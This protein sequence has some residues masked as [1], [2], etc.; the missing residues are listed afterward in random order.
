MAAKKRGEKRAGAA[1]ESG[2][3]P[4]VA[5]I[6]SSPEPVA[7]ETVEEPALPDGP[8]VVGIGASAGGLDAFKKFFIAMPRES[9]VALVL[10]P[11]LDPTHESL[12]VELLARHTAMP[13]TEAEDGMPVA[14]NRVYIIPPNKYMTISGGVLGLTGPVERRDAQTS[15]DLFLRS[16]AAD[17]QEK[18]VCIILSGTGS[19]GTLGLKAVKAAGGMAMVQDPKTAEYDRMPRSA[20]ATG[21][22]DYVLPVE[23]MPAVLIKYIQFLRMNGGKTE[24]KTAGG[25]DYLNQVLA[26]LRARTKYDFRGYRKRMLAR[27]VERRMGLNHFDQLADYVAFLRDQPDEVKHLTQDL[28]ISVTSFFR[29]PEALKALESEAVTSL[30]RAKGPDSVVRAWVAGCATGE[31]A[32]TI[33]ILLLEHIAAAQPSCRLQIFATDIDEGALEVAR[34]GIYPESIA[35]DV[36]PE[37]LGRFFTRVDESSYQVNKQLR[38]CITFAAQNL[39]GDA[40]FSKMDLVSCRNV[41][42]Y[43]EVDVQKR[44]IPLLHFALNE[45]GYLFLGPSE[46]IGRQ[47]DLFEAVSKKWRIFRRVGPSRVDRV[48]F[49]IT[50]RTE[51]SGSSWRPPDPSDIRAGRIAELAQRAL[52]AEFAPAAV[53]INRKLEILYFNGPINDYLEVPTGEPTRD[54]MNMAREGL[55]TK[56]RSTIHKAIIDN[57]AVTLTDGQVKRAGAYHPVTVTVRPLA[58]PRVAEGLLLVTFR[59]DG[60]S[61]VAPAPPQPSDEEPVVRQLE[62]ELRAT[63]EDLQSTIEELESSNEELKGS[64]EEVMSMNEE[65]QS[66]NEELET[67]KEELQS[68]NEELS[69]VNN[70]LHEKVG[71]LEGT[72]NDLSNLLNCTDVASVFLSTDIRIKRFTPASTRMFNLIATDVGRPI[73]DIA[74]KFNDPELLVD[75]EKVLHDLAQREKQVPCD[76]G[77]WCIRRILPYRTLDHRIEG[78]VLTFTDVTQLKLASEKAGLLATVLLDSYDAIW[79]HDFAGRITVWNKGAERMFGYSEAEALA[80]SAAALMPEEAWAQMH[81]IWQ[82][83]QE[84]ER[85]GP[86]EVDRITKGSRKI[87]AWVTATLLFDEAGHPTAI[88]HTE[89]DITDL[90]RARIALEQEVERRT[91]SLREKEERL[92]AILN[93]PDDGIITIRHDGRI[94]SVNPAAERMFGYTALEMIGQNVK[95]LMPAPYYREHDEYLARYSRT[96][97]KRI[98]GMSREVMA[99]RNDGSLFPIDLA[100]SEVESLGLYTA[101]LRDITLRKE[102]ELEVQEIAA[103]EQRRI[104]TDLHDQLGQELTAL[105]LLGESLAQSVEAQS[106]ADSAMA[107]KIA[108]SAKA[109]LGQIHGIS[110]GLIGFELDAL[111]LPAALSELASSVSASP[112]VHCTFECDPAIARPPDIPDSTA[113]HLLLIAREACTNSLRHARAENIVIRLSLDG[114]FAVLRITDNGVGLPDKFTEGL[115]LRIMR[116]RSRII[117]GRLSLDRLDP[118]GTVVTCTFAKEFADEEERR[119]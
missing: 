43:L 7:A 21:L 93:A 44:I 10:I 25:T 91:A 77:R 96:G 106:P 75:A 83:L 26:L 102:L 97:E 103:E 95:M 20:I 74:Q 114:P 24:E 51:P 56:L 73:S 58:F 82:R 66:A 28:F 117:Q 64:N 3:A 14:A 47:I 79:V 2:S 110:R 71:E 50:P 57:Q 19:H 32:Y 6:A 86:Y 109:L 118:H 54:L 61:D 39:I 67:S 60:A 22:A 4:D 8:A 98:I 69:T 5:A 38:E 40:P 111:G 76:D 30:L 88:A 80:M 16:L 78:V 104:G 18:A 55:R 52:I 15:I 33:G 17:Q 27:R 34:T 94:E 81:E 116:T 41:L 101:I 42:I 1:P 72:S 12:M 90:K 59:D 48:D 53:L 112:D 119:Q 92:R 13:V 31:E 107:R 99:R 100:V 46:T 11:H 23:E 35:A 65:L 115:G 63:R 49:P 89:R 84:G 9:D 105:G 62:Y 70:Q 87:D 36:S 68:L 85:V 45:G 108:R 113:R 37:R 29:E